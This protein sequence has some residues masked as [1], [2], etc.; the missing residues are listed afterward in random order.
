M[1]KVDEDIAIL[2]N[3][4]DGP[5][6]TPVVVGVELTSSDIPFLCDLFIMFSP[7]KS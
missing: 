3:L 2:P 5:S 4:E 7:D 1:G 6:F